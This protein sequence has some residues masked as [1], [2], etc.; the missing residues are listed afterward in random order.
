MTIQQAIEKATIMGYAGLVYRAETDCLS[1]MVWLGGK[2][3]RMAIY[4]RGC[5]FLD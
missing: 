4:A 5:W 3:A 1:A 2:Q